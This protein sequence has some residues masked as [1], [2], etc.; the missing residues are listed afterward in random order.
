M[1]SKPAPFNDVGSYSLS[2]IHRLWPSPTTPLFL[3]HLK[4]SIMRLSPLF[5]IQNVTTFLASSFFSVYAKQLSGFGT[6]A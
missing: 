5:T 1:R 6:L 4:L 2:L 3:C